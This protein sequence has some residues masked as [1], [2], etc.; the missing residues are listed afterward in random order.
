[1]T[2]S[3]DEARPSWDY[4]GHANPINVKD[5]YTSFGKFMHMFSQMEEAI[6]DTLAILVEISTGTESQLASEIIHSLTGSMRISVARDNFKRVLRILDAPDSVKAD[7]DFVFDQIGQINFFRDRVAHY[8]V[9]FQPDDQKWFYTSYPARVSDQEETI[10]FTT[11]ILEN[12]ARDLHDIPDRLDVALD[13]I[14]SDD[15]RSW[16][17]I[18]DEERASFRAP[19]L[20]RP[21]QLVKSGPKHRTIAERWSRPTPIQL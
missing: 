16:F 13:P 11:E 6:N 3:A 2:Y 4:P 20:F 14:M 8:R 15:Y 1:M 10:A 12:M 7:T 5:Y 19:W 18:S 9:H 21:S 17:R